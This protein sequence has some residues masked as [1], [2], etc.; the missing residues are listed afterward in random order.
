VCSSV[1]KQEA[2]AV[3]LCHGW[4]DGQLNPYG[5]TRRQPRREGILCDAYRGANRY[6]VLYRTQDAKTE[7]ARQ[8]R[9]A[10]FMG[11]L[12]RHE[13]VHPPPAKAAAKPRA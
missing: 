2:I 5:C 1:G 3:A 6:A 7:K 11:M 10:T 13:V 12:E 4:T 8:A 9:I